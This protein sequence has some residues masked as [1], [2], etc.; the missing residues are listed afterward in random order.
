M[1]C[2]VCGKFCETDGDLGVEYGSSPVVVPLHGESI[3]CAECFE[4]VHC[5][6]A[7]GTVCIA[8]EMSTAPLPAGFIS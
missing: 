3:K 7:R 6:C 5:T 8:C 4:V 2:H 1:Q